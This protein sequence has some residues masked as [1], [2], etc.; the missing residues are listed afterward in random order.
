MKPKQGI[1]EVGFKWADCTSAFQNKVIP[2]FSKGG[3]AYE[4][5][6][7]M[8]VWHYQKHFYFYK[9]CF[10]TIKGVRYGY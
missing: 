7:F 10:L 6:G 9:W 4:D 1:K 5:F 8:S 2:I 3:G